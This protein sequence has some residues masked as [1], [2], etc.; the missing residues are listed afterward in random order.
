MD[1]DVITLME[2]GSVRY[3]GSWK[4]SREGRSVANDHEFQNALGKMKTPKPKVQSCLACEQRINVNLGRTHTFDC[5][6]TSLPSL[7]TDSL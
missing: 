2:D 3:N 1:A 7:A 5:R 4:Y 6:Q